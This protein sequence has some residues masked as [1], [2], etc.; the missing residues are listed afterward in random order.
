MDTC[1][2][3]KTYPKYIFELMKLTIINENTTA[4]DYKANDVN[5]KAV[6]KVRLTITIVGED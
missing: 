3:E 6:K 5:D 2:T 1:T 4:F